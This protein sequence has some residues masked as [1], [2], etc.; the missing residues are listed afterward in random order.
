[1]RVTNEQQIR[2]LFKDNGG[3]S[4]RAVKFKNKKPLTIQWAVL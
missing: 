4:G 3:D 2:D 1:M